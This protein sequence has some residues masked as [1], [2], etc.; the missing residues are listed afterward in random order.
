MSKKTRYVFSRDCSISDVGVFGDKL[1]DPIVEKFEKGCQ[2]F[3][4]TDGTINLIDI[5]YSVLKKIGPADVDIV[6]FAAGVRDRNNLRF[7]LE[8]K[9]VRGLRVICDTNYASF[10]SGH[11][12]YFHQILGRDNCRTSKV[13]AKFI[14]ASNESYNVA[15][16]TSANLN[17]NPRVEFVMLIDNQEVLEFYERFVDHT[18]SD[19]PPGVRPHSS[20]AHRSFQKFIVEEARLEKEEEARAAA[21]SAAT[22]DDLWFGDLSDDD[23]SLGGAD[24]DLFSVEDEDPFGD[25]GLGGLF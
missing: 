3:T 24:E 21:R 18:F 8:S 17:T 9:L 15:I 13:H 1:S 14:L 19:M 2:I 11:G 23:L 5:L 4:I 12:A 25:D 10:K 6:V 20:L 22:K 7:L 16:F